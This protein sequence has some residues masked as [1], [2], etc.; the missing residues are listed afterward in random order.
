MNVN[1]GLFPPIERR[2]RGKD[3]RKAMSERG[4]QDLTEWMKHSLAE[5][6]EKNPAEKIGYQ[7]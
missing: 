6:S 3:K 1:F 7:N 2:L 4:L 5:D